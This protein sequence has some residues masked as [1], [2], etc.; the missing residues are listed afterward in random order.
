MPK[1][2]LKFEAAVIREYKVDKPVFTIGRKPDND[3]M[4]DNQA[5]SG[6]HCK[7]FQGGDTYFVEDLGSTNGTLVNGKKVLKSGLHHGDTINIIK[8]SLIFMVDGAPA[9]VQAAPAPEAQQSKPATAAPAQAAPAPAPAP[10]AV[11]VP[12]SQ[13][14][15]AKA[16]LE[17]LEGAADAKTDHELTSLSTYIG[18]SSQANIQYKG[19]GMF[20]LGPDMA[21]VIT[22]RPEGYYL[23]PIKEGYAKHNGNQL[24]KK[25]LLADDDVIEVGGTK[26]RFYIVK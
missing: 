14:P 25:A 6:H 8:Y 11:P 23:I 2:L 9:P 17:V 12:Q 26:F 15:R 22:M 20:N 4:L 19:S 7:L 3:I 1:I 18:K 5:V 21:V 10:A 13:K 16:G 24:D